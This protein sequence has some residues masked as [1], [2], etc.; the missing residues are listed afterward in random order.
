MVHKMKPQSFLVCGLTAVLI[1]AFAGTTAA[2]AQLVVIEST[3][4]GIRPGARF[5]D[6]DVL[7][8]PA[9]SEIR[10]VLPSGK[11]RTV[12]GPFSGT[13]GEL[14]K[15]EPRNEGVMVW[16][17]EFLRTGGARESAPG[18]TRGIA[19]VAAKPI[20]FSWSAVPVTAS[21]SVCVRKGARLE[22]VRPP[23]SRAEDAVVVDAQNA[24]RG[25]AQWEAGSTTAA[26][27]ANLV[28]RSNAIY[29]VQL[30]GGRPQRQITLRVL[31]KLPADEDVLAEL[32]RFGCKQQFEAWVKGPTVS[33]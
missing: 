21:G 13:V 19:P 16:L 1:A 6:S 28:P 4:S 24:T 17:M 12:R 32:H 22:L 7:S 2:L 14:N 31:D 27:P 30:S 8:V 33:R 29:Y 10:V 25:E 3:A 15:G 11:T 26:W 23:S 5:E 18:A 9:G 20:G